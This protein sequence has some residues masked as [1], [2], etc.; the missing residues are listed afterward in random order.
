MTLEFLYMGNTNDVMCL[1]LYVRVRSVS[2]VSY[3]AGVP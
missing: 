2:G 1:G 3:D